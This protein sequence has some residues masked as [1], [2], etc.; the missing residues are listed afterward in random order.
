MR[1]VTIVLAGIISV[2][3]GAVAAQQ[4]E[5]T[6]GDWRQPVMVRLTRGD[7]LRVKADSAFVYNHHGERLNRALNVLS[8]KFDSL[9]RAQITAISRKD[10]IIDSLRHRV[11]LADSVQ[12]L[13]DSV[14]NQFWETV[15]IQQQAWDSLHAQFKDLDSLTHRSVNNTDRALAYAKRVRITSYLTSGLAGGIMGGFGIRFGKQE[16]FQWTGALLGA[17]A[18]VGLNWLALKILH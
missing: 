4:R 6:L 17:G 8:L 14:V 11:S 18:G 12:K 5:K 9:N 13:R 7:L 15:R 2:D 10:S 3:A 16:G 1:T